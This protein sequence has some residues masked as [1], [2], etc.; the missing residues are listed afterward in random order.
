MQRFIIAVALLVTLLVPNSII[1][2]QI[3]GID[4]GANITLSPQFPEPGATVT[5]TLNAYSSETNGAVIKWFLNGT[6]QTNFTNSRTMT[7]VAGEM[8]ETS[9]ITAS[10]QLRSGGVVSVG[11]AATPSR[12]DL[13][14][15][16]DTTT[17]LHYPGRALPSRG[18]TVR[19]TAIPT[20]NQNPNNLTY[21]WSVDNQVLYGGSLVGKQTATFVAPSARTFLIK[22]NITDKDGRSIGNKLEEIQLTDPVLRFYEV[23]PLRGI[24]PVAI[25]S[26]HFLLGSEMTV[27]AEPYHLASNRKAEDYFVEWKINNEKIANPSSNPQVIT[28]QNS[29]GSGRFVVNFHLRNFKNALQGAQDQFVINF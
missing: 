27:R 5:A 21:S 14:I 17:P 7:F 6:E 3:P 9:N 12:V 11:A 22:V 24:S 2:A 4:S 10:L 15:E 16:A 18:S 28:L 1:E 29:G 20:T 25:L 26:P 23:N 8:G 13:I 19:I